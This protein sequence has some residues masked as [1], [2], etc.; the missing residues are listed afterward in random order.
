MASNIQP[1]PNS[2]SPGR[3]LF[4]DGQNELPMLEITT[5]W[6]TAEI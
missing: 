3:V 1:P 4:L 2:T 6:S 5:P